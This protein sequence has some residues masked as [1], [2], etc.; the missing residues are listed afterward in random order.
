MIAEKGKRSQNQ[1]LAIVLIAI[2]VVIVLMNVGALTWFTTLRFL[3]LWP[4]VLIAMV[5]TSG[6]VD[7]TGSWSFLSHSWLR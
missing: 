4:V 7:A 6:L 5:L 3:Q 1:T 2:G